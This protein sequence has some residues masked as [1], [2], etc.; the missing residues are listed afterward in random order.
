[1]RLI[2]LL[3]LLGLAACAGQSSIVRD[4]PAASFKTHKSVDELEKCLTGSLSKLDDVTSV[5]SAGVTTLMLGERTKPSMLI[6]LAPR[7]VTVTTN[8][9]P[10]TRNLIVACI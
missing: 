6:D 3:P 5:S 1:M 9:A 10:G 7:R 8:F 4:A 2:S